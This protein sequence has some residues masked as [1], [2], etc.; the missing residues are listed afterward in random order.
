MR[1]TKIIIWVLV[2]LSGSLQGQSPLLDRV[3]F[4]QVNENGF[5]MSFPFAGG[6]DQPQFNEMDLNGDGRMDLVVFDRAGNKIIPFL[7]DGTPNT[8]DYSFAPSYEDQFPEELTHY[9]VFR[10]FNCDGQM[11]IFTSNQDFIRVFQNVSTGANFQFSV[12]VDSLRSDYGA[13]AVALIVS[14]FDVPGL[15][16]ID[17]DGDIDILTFDPGGNFMEYHKNLSVEN[18]GD[19]NAMAFTRVNACWGKFQESALG[20]GISLNVSCRV[21]PGTNYDPASGSVHAGSTVAIFDENNDGI[22][23]VVLG[24]LTSNALTYLRNGGT[25]SNA[26]IDS[27]HNNFPNYDTPAL[28]DNFPGAYFLDVNNDGRED[29][30]AAPNSTAATFN[31][32]NVWYYQNIS[33]TGGVQL[34][35]TSTKFLQKDMIDLGT[36][37]Y[38]VFF[39][40]NNDGLKDLLVGNYNTKIQAGTA[41]TT[42]GLALFLNTGTSTLPSFQLVTRDFENLSATLGNNLYGFTP[43]LG[44]LDNDGDLDMMI[45]DA[46]GKLHYF[47]NIAPSGQT[48]DFVL[49]QSNYKNI[50]VGNF[51]T[52]NLVDIDRDG[53]LDMVIGEMSGTLNYFHNI[54]T[55]QVADFS[56]SPDNS[57]WG[58]VDTDPECCTGWS[59]PAVFENPAT[60]RYDLLVGSEKA[61]ILYYE[62]I[63][64][65]LG[66]N[67]T[68]DDPA[69]GNIK[70]G[71]RTS[72]A[73]ADLNGDNKPEYIT[74]NLRGGLGFYAEQGTYVVGARGTRP[75]PAFSIF[76]NPS[77]G[78]LYLKSEVLTGTDLEISIY[79]MR[80][81]EVFRTVQNYSGSAMEFRVGALP[82][83]LYFI[84]VLTK[85]RSLGSHKWIVK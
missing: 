60:G 7:N 58:G 20:S 63:E 53:K 10:D 55:A 85:D 75:G 50:D 81:H 38:P 56:S 15:A 22:K 61:N 26:L 34:S 84:H 48:A 54:G 78:A 29:M 19:C 37:A 8:V 44:D 13:G 65:E 42:S 40:F 59:V 30:I 25:V 2:L 31:Y 73:A 83:G 6:M 67:F 76:P 5:Q 18:S 21:P 70:E 72:I 9:A 49:A 33:A 3:N 32:Q 35:Q 36:C 52:P 27:V 4:I 1:G 28:I 51:S 80:G 71:F 11:D 68:L 24:D 43:T 69:F 14:N 82:A 57:N 66:S 12:W 62:D 39:D 46:S 77:Q 47:E 79:D 74:G 23:D 17:N 64:S 45:G 41:G 16:D